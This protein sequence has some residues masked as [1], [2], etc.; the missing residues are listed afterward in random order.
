M[1]LQT[2]TLF[3]DHEDNFVV[4]QSL[5]VEDEISLSETAQRLEESV[6]TKV[7]YGNFDLHSTCS[8]DVKLPISKAEA[9]SSRFP[10]PVSS[11]EIDLLIYSQTN[12]NTSKNTKW[13]MNIFDVWSE[14]P[15]ANG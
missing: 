14:N 1:S 13:A 11:Q 7:D 15:V 6:D 8:L 5:E 9:D 2:Q 10:I 4:S 3:S 12:A